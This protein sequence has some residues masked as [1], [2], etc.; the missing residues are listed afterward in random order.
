M[1]TVYPRA[2]QFSR[3]A[4]LEDCKINSIAVAPRWS[5]LLNTLNDYYITP[6]DFS[7][8][9]HTRVYYILQALKV[10]SLLSG[11][12]NDNNTNSNNND[13]NKYNDINNKALQS[14]MSLNTMRNQCITSIHLI[15]TRAGRCCDDNTNNNNNNNT[16]LNEIQ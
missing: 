7:H 12:D 16:H 4:R 9:Y 5:L 15:N 3:R 8:Q 13:G 6:F 10:T 2:Q 11:F 1:Y 14:T